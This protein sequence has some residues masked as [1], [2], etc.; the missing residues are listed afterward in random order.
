MKSSALALIVSIASLFASGCGM[1]MAFTQPPRVDTEA[2]SAGG[3]S[4]DVVIERLGLRSL[5]LRTSMEAE[6]TCLSFMRGLRQD[7]R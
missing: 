5:V 4:R 6:R 1:Y 2:L 7:G 3:M